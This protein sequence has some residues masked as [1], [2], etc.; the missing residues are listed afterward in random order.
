ML[1]YLTLTP[2]FFLFLP[3][4]AMALVKLS[5]SGICHD[6]YSK[7]FSRTKNYTA[8]DNLKACLDTGGK[9]PKNYKGPELTRTK[10]LTPKPS[11]DGALS[12]SLLYNR[13]QWPHWI[14]VDKD[15][16]NTR[17]EML[18]NTSK[19][20]VKF[21]STKQCSVVEGK[22]DDPFSGKTW[23]KAGDVDIDHVV[24]LKWANGHGG[25]SWNKEQKTTFA[26]DFENLLVVEDNLNQSKGAKGP[27]EWMPPNH[28]YRCDYVA[29]F[30]NVVTK[31]NL[32]Y[33][34]SEKRIISK[35]L[36]TCSN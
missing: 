1:R 34:S 3:L 16:Q 28:L 27:D 7:H 20:D 12:Y 35:M 18:I 10:A 29:H 31:Y 17:A 26:N 5:N 36:S 8:F 32:R 15:C 14:D 11:S 4:D 23:T 19:T 6:S 21:R 22:W 24:P 13:K 2:V 9:L 25:S 33:I 30:N